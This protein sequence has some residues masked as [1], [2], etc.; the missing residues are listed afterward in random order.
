MKGKQPIPRDVLVTAG[1]SRTIRSTLAEPCGRDLALGNWMS[2]CQIAEDGNL[3]QN[4]G[5]PCWRAPQMN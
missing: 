2:S 5:E 1:A 3:F 4:E